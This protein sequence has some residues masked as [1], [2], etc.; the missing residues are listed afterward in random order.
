[1]AVA[2]SFLNAIGMDWGRILI[3]WRVFRHSFHPAVKGG[4]CAGGGNPFRVRFIELKPGE[5]ASR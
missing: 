1:M 4:D 2:W 5:E 3:A